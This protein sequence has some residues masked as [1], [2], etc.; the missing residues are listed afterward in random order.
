MTT[1][2]AEA[3]AAKIV[4]EECGRR[5]DA[6]REQARDDA[7]GQQDDARHVEG[8]EGGAACWPYMAPKRIPGGET[9]LCGAGATSDRQGYTLEGLAFWRPRRPI[10][11]PLNRTPVH[12]RAQGTGA[13]AFAGEP[14]PGGIG[15]ARADAVLASDRRG[16]CSDDD[17]LLRQ[18]AQDGTPA[19][20]GR[21]RPR[22]RRWSRSGRWSRARAS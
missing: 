13:G 11:C 18:T 3:M 5:A 7:R 9:G 10:P 2:P 14:P 6:G 12:R 1:R 8:A 4:R 17:R 16:R 15:L 22:D 20:T 19:P 21:R